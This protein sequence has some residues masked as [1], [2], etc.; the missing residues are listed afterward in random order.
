MGEDNNKGVFFVFQVSLTTLQESELRV[1]L[2]EP[3]HEPIKGFTVDEADSVTESGMAQVVS[4]GGNS[5]LSAFTGKAV[6][7]RFYFKNCKLYSFQFR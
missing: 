2:L 3:N 4:W 7:L 1:E 5:D 6:K